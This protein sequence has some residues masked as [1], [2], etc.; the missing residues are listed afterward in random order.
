MSVSS[1]SIKQ[2][3]LAAASVDSA[4]A[5]WALTVFQ[6]SQTVMHGSHCFYCSYS[7]IKWRKY[8]NDITVFFTA[9][10]YFWWMIGLFKVTICNF[11][12]DLQFQKKWNLTIHIY[13]SHRTVI[14]VKRSYFME[15]MSS[16]FP[17]DVLRLLCLNS[18]IHEGSW[19]QHACC[20]QTE[21]AAAAAGRCWWQLG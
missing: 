9:A 1:F 17:C 15:K 21:A 8:S 12:R 4:A 14:L 10:L 13:M 7:N 18:V 11:D 3:R 6:A 2:V 5:C 16:C 19:K 20:L